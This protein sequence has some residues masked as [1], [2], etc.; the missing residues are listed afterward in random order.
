MKKYINAL[1]IFAGT[2]I[3]VGI[4][5]LPYATAQFGFFPIIIYFI[6]LGLIVLIIQLAYGEI[7]LRTNGQHRMPGYAKIYL[8]QK[9]KNLTLF[10]NAI[11]LYGAM[12]AYIIIGGSFLASLL[13]PIFGGNDLTYILIYFVAGSFIIFLGSRTVA[14]YE[15][16]SL[17][18]FFG[19]FVF[20][21]YKGIPLIDTQN[22]LTFDLKNIILPYGVILFSIAGITVIPETREILADKAK[23]LKSLII[24]GSLIP[25]ITSLVFIF[26]VLGVSGV[27]TT[28]DALAGLESVLGRQTLIAGFIFGIITTFT[29]YLTIGLTLKKIFWY[30]L[31]FSHFNSWVIACFI[32]LILYFIGVQ[33]F[34]KI[35]GFSAAITA[36]IE[37]TIVFLIYLKAKQKGQRVPEYQIRLKQWVLYPLVLLFAIGVVATA[38]TL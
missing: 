10:S 17:T 38:L 33:D 23:S 9:A 30:D 19:V 15:I 1:A 2:A 20:L 11:G 36:L 37:G 35:I 29:S 24:I 27:N 31:K 8:G 21:L 34:I 18:I 22:F 7:C 6:F 14:K 3:G 28:K 32:P 5:G 16:F 26:L 4:F 13:S 25:I 12:L